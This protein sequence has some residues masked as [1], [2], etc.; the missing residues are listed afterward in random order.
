MGFEE[1]PKAEISELTSQVK[2]K[3]IPAPRG[4]SR[5]GSA[6]HSAFPKLLGS[7]QHCCRRAESSACVYNTA[8]SD[9]TRQGSMD[10]PMKQV[11]RFKHG[12]EPY[13]EPVQVSQKKVG[14]GKPWQ[15]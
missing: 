15:V 9:G 8:M 1:I 3:Q 5:K 12:P 2:R 11:Y 14:L 7:Q 10:C 6:T 4:P 13:R